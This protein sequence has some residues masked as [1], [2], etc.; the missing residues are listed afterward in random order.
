VSYEVDGVTFQDEPLSLFGFENSRLLVGSDI[1]TNIVMHSER[2][3]QGYQYV[4]GTDY[5]SGY[6]S[7]ES[8]NLVNL[9]ARSSL[10]ERQIV[11]PSLR[12]GN[13]FRDASIVTFRYTTADF[14]ENE[15]SGTV[16]FSFEASAVI[17]HEYLDA[18]DVSFSFIAQAPPI[19]QE[20]LIRDD[21][22]TVAFNFF[23]TGSETTD[24]LDA[25]LVGAA[26]NGWVFVPTNEGLLSDDAA[27]IVFNFA[28]IEDDYGSTGDV[29]GYSSGPMDGS[30][31]DLSGR[32]DLN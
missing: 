12:S 15:D 20:T 5:T 11:D 22:A 3:G 26:P 27:T 9:I 25:D 13:S 28:P 8:G 23:A 1:A 29:Y 18:D 17:P 7:D 21:A 16:T 6:E 30:L 4:I 32:E 10:V 14:L 31:G 19:T 2:G 24:F